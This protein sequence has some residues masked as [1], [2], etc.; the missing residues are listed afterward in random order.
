MIDLLWL[1]LR[2]VGFVVF[3]AAAGGAL[4]LEIFR[5]ELSEPAAAL[6]RTRAGHCALAGLAVALAQGLFEPL[7]LAGDWDGIQQSSLWRL[8]WA[9]PVALGQWLRVAG[10]VALRAGIVRCALAWR[11]LALLGVLLILGAFLVSGHTVT[12]A[13]RAPLGALLGLHV[14][15]AAFW[16]GAVQALRAL[17]GRFPPPALVPLLQ[18]FSAYAV[19]LVPLLGGAGIALAVALLPDAAALRRPYGLLLCLKAVLFAALLG[20]AALN[21]SRLVPALA[22]GQPCASASL[23]HTLAAEA[24]LM[25]AV[26]IATAVLTGQFAPQE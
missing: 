26:L 4:Y 24:L 19:W 5:R 7:R 21:R 1:A 16:F 14:A 2:A 18:R 23:G 3:L 15:V 9:S 13:H 11:A 25:S 6:L 12:A 22:R 8:A 17:R 10:L 20:L